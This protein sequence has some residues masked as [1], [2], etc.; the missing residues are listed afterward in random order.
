ML[1][2]DYGSWNDIKTWR[3]PL[4]LTELCEM[5]NVIPQNDGL[6][7]EPPPVA[8]AMYVPIPYNAR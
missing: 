2:R 8:S 6:R 3:C 5:T 1:R 4:P 7:A